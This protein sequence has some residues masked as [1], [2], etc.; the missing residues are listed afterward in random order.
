MKKII[1]ILSFVTVL[2]FLL[3]ANETTQ[4]IRGKVADEATGI[5]IVGATVVLLESDPMRGTTTDAN[6]EF[7][8]SDVPLGRQGVKIDFIG[9]K[10]SVVNN[11]LLKSGKETLLDIKLVE[12]VIE[13]EE[14]TVKAFN[15]KDKTINE[16]A[17]ISARSFTV[18]ETERFAGSL[19]DPARMVA[20]YAGVMTQNDARNDIIIRG[21]S[22]IGVLWLLDG[23]EIP[24]PNHFGALGTTG[25]P[26][27]MLNNNLLS[28][29]DFLT[30]AFPASY[31]NAMA[32]AFDLRMRPGNNAKTE[33]TGQIGFNGFEAGVEGPLNI[34]TQ[35]ATPSYIAN[36]RYS[37]LEVLDKIGFDL[38]TG[39]AI[40]QY[41]DF[42][43]NF[44][45][46]GSKLGS[47]KV[48]G[49]WGRSYIE[50][51][52]DLSDTTSNSYNPLGTATNF[53]SDLAVV[54]LSHTYFVNSES[55]VRTIVSF[56][57]TQSTTKVDSLRKYGNDIFES[58]IYTGILD[59]SKLSVS[60]SFK[61]KLSAKNNFEVG[62]TGDK[63]FV[64][65][66]D[67]A[68]SVDLGML[69]KL[70]GTRGEMELFR[71]FAQWQHRFTDDLTSYAGLH[72]QFFN[73][74][75]ESVVEPRLGL[76]WQFTEKQSINL[77]MGFHS[78]MQPRTTYFYE[79]L[80][81]TANI[82]SQT[83]K[84]LKFSRSNHYV[85][86]YNYL[87]NRDFRLRVETYYQDLYNIPVRKGENWYAMLNSGDNFGIFNYDSLENKGLGRN[88]GV[89]L[90]LEKFL[91]KGYYF[92]FTASL[93]DSKYKGYEG[94]WRNTAFNGNYVFNLL[95]GYEFKVGENSMITLDL[96]T[97]WAGGKRYIPLD[98]E[99]SIE[100]YQ[101]E[102]DYSRAYEKKY[103]DYFR[104]DLRI[105]FKMNKSK[106]SQEWAMD[107]QNLSNFQSLFMEGY[108]L[109]KQKVYKTYQQGFIPMFLY[110]IQF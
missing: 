87:F 12:S 72:Y 7:V 91:G 89:E 35:G 75:K 16:M 106:F 79:S 18:E 51:G 70:T 56:Q 98:L 6:G 24:N 27:S 37:T 38:G 88:Y 17:L 86:G 32:G 31:G 30:G 71:S 57:N 104:T 36:F 55:R 94:G 26:V 107:L 95:G 66:A 102:Y 45:L 83:N 39:S 44:N 41:K 29:S 34:G 60:T 82:Y 14:V 73:L 90:T 92:L 108:D 103:D 9:Y 69:R 97:V 59:E 58:L 48:I 64:D 10:P 61:Y 78:Q 3:L 110:R 25:G 109:Q 105:G 33:Y 85:V 99:A 43:F 76:Q 84:N 46:P 65:F 28:N 50:L 22:P 8:L 100:N 101:A 80:D 47:F 54:G 62:V 15:R 1:S 53:G 67:S 4:T 13:V 11:L 96:K 19:G 63:Y 42:T 5:P 81:T 2:P 77:G 49:L 20:N 93:F 68:L 23:I 21:N 74:N 52:R 40:P